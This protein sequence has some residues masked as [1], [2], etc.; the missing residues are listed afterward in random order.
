MKKILFIVAAF[1]TTFAS[2]QIKMPQASTTQKINQDFGM[3]AIELTYSRPNIKGRTVLKEKSELAPLGSIW[4]L[5]ANAATKIKFTDKVTIGGTELE[6][7]TYVIYAVPG[8]DMWDVIFNKGLNNWGTD[9]YKE[10][11]DVVHVKVKA[12]KAANFA[13]SFTMQIINVAA[14]TCELHMTWGS[15][16]V[17]VPISTNIKDRVRAQIEKAL[18]ADN[19]QANTYNTAANFYYEFDKDYTKALVNI[20]KAVEASKDAY[21]MVLL[22]ARIEKALGDKVS[23]KASAEKCIEMATGKNAD[24]VTFANELIKNL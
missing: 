17:A 9:G 13:E 12:E 8:K 14:E 15:V 19:I 11:E 22:K 20:T 5:G 21:W 24:Y 1:V 6:A 4:R 16:Q 18:A 3:G 7:G 10:A 23:A 2:A